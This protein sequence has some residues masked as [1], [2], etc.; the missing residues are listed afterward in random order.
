MIF[1]VLHIQRWCRISSINSIC[2]SWKLL[3]F[4]A[5]QFRPPE[6]QSWG[7]DAAT[8][9]GHRHW[10]QRKKQRQYGSLLLGKFIVHSPSPVW[11]C[12]QWNDI[13]WLRYLQFSTLCVS[14]QHHAKRNKS[15]T[16]SETSWWELFPNMCFPNKCT[17]AICLN[18]CSSIGPNKQS[19]K[20]TTKQTNISDTPKIK[21]TYLH[22]SNMCV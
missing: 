6:Q 4:P 22:F 20:Q 18:A 5:E 17:A 21:S 12:M 15:G 13:P 1:R 2:Q 8:W 16:V 10:P 11:L 19:N 7:P 14:M 3:V 9:H